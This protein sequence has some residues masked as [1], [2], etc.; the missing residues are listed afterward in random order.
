MKD[1]FHVQM[2]DKELNSV[3]VLGLA[4]VGD[5]VYELMTRASLCISGAHTTQNIHRKTVKLVCA[6]AQASASKKIINLLDEEEKAAFRRGRNAKVNS[7]PRSS[8]MS[9]YHYATGLETLF[10]YLY[11]KGRIERINELFVIILED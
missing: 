9:E 5:A 3:S 1:L 4:N 2:T 11:L 6:T 7:I 10:G 8:S